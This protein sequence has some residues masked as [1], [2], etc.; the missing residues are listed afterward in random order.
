[1]GAA[2]LT[3]WEEEEE[4][5]PP[6][7][8]EPLPVSGR[9]PACLDWVSNTLHAPRAG[10]HLFDGDGMLQAVRLRGGPARCA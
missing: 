1:M 4:G 6:L 7:R 8:G 5:H 2:Q 3:G 9:V 10:H